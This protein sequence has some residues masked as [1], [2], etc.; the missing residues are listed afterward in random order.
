MM[1]DV[2]IIGAGPAGL[3]SALYLRRANKK[4]LVLEALTF[5]GQIINTLKIDN[6]PS[7]PHISGYDFAEK[8]YNQ[9]KELDTEI[10]FEKVININN[11]D[12]YKEVITNDNKYQT[13]S[14]IIATGNS[15][16]KLD[17]NDSDKYL[18]HGLSYCSTCDGSFYKNKI[19][20]VYGYEESAL[21]DTLYLSDICKKVYLINPKDNFICDDNLGE[22][23][24]SKNNIEII[25]NTNILKLNGN[26]KLESIDLNSN[27]LK[28][29]GLFVS[30]GRVPE[31]ENFKKIIKLSKDG[32]I[33][34]KEDCH[35][36][37]SGIFVAG[38]ARCKDLR[39][40]V[41]ATS[42]GAVAAIEAIKYLNR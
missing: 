5:G 23:I 18:G 25:Y 17:I 20:S 3:T 21:N 27:N 28:I 12:S 40:L 4:V 33:D 32:Y 39:Q 1:Y 19:V 15:S 42:D 36:N 31:T 26:D 41:T 24:K 8:L 38:D 11:L 6:Y 14:I 35:T 34:A 9:V 13:K 22:K 16:K 7:L 2:I 10:K 37:I 30:L 29:D